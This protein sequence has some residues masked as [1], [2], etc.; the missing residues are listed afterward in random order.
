M[1]T[2]VSR[3]QALARTLAAAAGLALLLLATV[4]AVAARPVPAAAPNSFA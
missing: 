3:A 2:L 4:A 1:H